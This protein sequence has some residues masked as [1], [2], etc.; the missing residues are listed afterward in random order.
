MKRIQL[1]L[2]LLCA[3]TALLRA[4]ESDE[5]SPTVWWGYWSSSM[6]LTEA[7][8]LPDGTNRCAIR[9]MPTTAAVLTDAKVYGLRFYLSDKTAVTAASAWITTRPF[10][11][12]VSEPNVVSK[13][14]ALSDLKDLKHDGEA[15]VVLFDTPY[16]P[17]PAGNRY[18]AAY[19][20]FNLELSADV[21]TTP[22]MLMTS[23][24]A[25]A[26][27]NT[28]FYDW[29]DIG[30]SYGPLALQL[31][32]GSDEFAA[33]ACAPQP[34]GVGTLQAGETTA[35][36]LPFRVDGCTAVADI[37]YTLSIDGTA[38]TSAHY[39]LPESLGE[40]GA[41]FT[42]PV[43]IDLPTEAA[44]HDVGVEVTKVNGKANES[45][46]ALQTSR[47]LL[48][49]RPALKRVVMEEFTGTWCPN[50]P[51]GM[52]GMHVMEEQYGD[53]FIGIAIHNDDP[54][55]IASYDQSQF[56]KNAMAVLKGYPGCVV[57]RTIYCDPYCGL[58]LTS[59]HCNVGEVVGPLMATQEC[60]ADV[61]VSASWT[62]ADETQL[63]FDVATTF[64]Y[65]EASDAP[66]ALMLVVMSNGLTGTTSE[67][68]QINKFAEEGNEYTDPDMDYWSKGQRYQTGV[69]YDHVAVDVAGVNSGIAGS[70]SLPLV[71]G[72]AQHYNY[73]FDLAS[74]AIIQNKENVRAVALLLNTETG[75]VVNAASCAVPAYVATGIDGVNP[76]HNASAQRFYTLDGRHTEHPQ[77]GIYIVRQGDGSVKKV[78]R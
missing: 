24:Q 71:C 7:V 72:E 77:R 64:R 1:F 14:I 13:Q 27:A 53:R 69:V 28:N 68:T 49:D 63:Q 26:D 41:T 4:Q 51:R 35:L 8:E 74:N 17:L 60:P 61:E 42:V 3:C 76:A 67:W 54:M 39:A 38:I 10:P 6:G 57:D 11:G 59:K 44:W 2:L 36:D 48:L 30:S 75:S 37:D 15:N 16:T 65:S 58:D 43:S 20:G 33:N 55:A 46:A 62:D 56:K 22:C 32:V 25:T 52:V 66:F 21:A 40:L 45:T 29:T 12:S 18:A 5:T 31:L 73:D 23:G 78:L 34:L 9:L 19:V 70:I 50:C 47:L